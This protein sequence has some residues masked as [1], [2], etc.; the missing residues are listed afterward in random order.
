[1]VMIDVRAIPA[2]DLIAKFRRPSGKRTLA[3]EHI[4]LIWRPKV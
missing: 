1:M 2:Q 3:A 4:P